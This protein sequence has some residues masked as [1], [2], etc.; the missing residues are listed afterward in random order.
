MLSPSPAR[1]TVLRK[2]KN[3]LIFK[4]KTHDSIMLSPPSP[5]RY[6]VL[7]EKKFL[8]KFKTFFFYMIL[9]DLFD[10]LEYLEFKP[11]NWFKTFFYMILI[12]VNDLRS[13]RIFVPLLL[14]IP[15][16]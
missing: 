2:K 4:I 13:F 9:N 7:S 3:L 6:T 10:N 5:A 14:N 11:Q 15:W 12:I 16:F 1:Y 8:N